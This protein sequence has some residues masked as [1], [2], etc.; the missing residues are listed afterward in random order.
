M[1]ARGAA[2]F[3]EG[4]VLGAIRCGSGP[5]P[6][7]AVTV[8]IA[9]KP[10]IRNLWN[11]KS[12]T[13]PLPRDRHVH[14]FAVGVFR[15]RHLQDQALP[16]QLEEPLKVAPDVTRIDRADEVVNEIFF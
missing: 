12:V 2:T 14:F 6:E 1:T 9:R 15:H 13:Q 10:T 16:R 8:R 3:T 4:A 7:T 5:W 11:K